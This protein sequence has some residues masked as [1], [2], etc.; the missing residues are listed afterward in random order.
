[1]LLSRFGRN[2]VQR[3]QLIQR[4]ARGDL[5]ALAEAEKTYK[6][7]HGNYSAKLEEL[8]I[9]TKEAL[10]RVSFEK[11]AHCTD[12]GATAEAFKASAS[13]NVDADPDEDVWTIDER[14]QVSH[15]FDDLTSSSPASNNEPI[16]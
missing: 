15:A 1:M 14:G 13:A 11:S 2:E 16:H 9:D 8:G 3:A 4:T 7:D 6:R 5:L 10:Y 12:C